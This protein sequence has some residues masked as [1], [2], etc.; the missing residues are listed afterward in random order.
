M[1]TAAAV[2]VRIEQIKLDLIHADP[3]QVRREFHV[4]Q[5]NELA[6]SIKARGLVQPV[7]VV[8]N[9][10]GFQLVAGERRLRAS[11]LAGRADI[12]AVVRTDLKPEDIPVLQ[13]VENLQ[14]EGLSLAEVSGG[15]TALCA[16]RSHD[17][18]AKLLGKSK[19]WV[20]KRVS[21]SA[22]PEPVKKLVDQGAI[23]DPEIALG[24]AEVLAIDAEE[25]KDLLGRIEKPGPFGRPVTREDIR[26]L[27]KDA[28][29]EAQWRQQR[30]A[31]EQRRKAAD[32]KGDKKPSAQEQR[33]VRERE[34][35]E[36]RRKARR[37][38]LR[39]I[40]K[41]C[42]ALVKATQPKLAAVFG[43]KCKTDKDGE[44][45]GYY[46]QEIY[47]RPEL[48]NLEF[49][50]EPIPQHTD[51]VKFNVVLN[52]DGKGLLKLLKQ[53]GIEAKGAPAAPAQE[54]PAAKPK[55]VTGKKK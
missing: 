54:K 36:E 19:S 13:L 43:K 51:Q 44:L 50:R 31:E 14:R 49:G 23:A 4:D 16:S 47:I 22:L 6:D 34:K 42:A 32:A 3:K 17:E 2:P 40:E 55:P 29:Q 7:V 26:D 30:E 25:G 45:L 38:K 15:V 8:P 46:Q 12:P 24:A 21:V 35:E 53:L 37:A 27:V 1:S 28:K 48:A 18:V 33:W 52:L 11:K 39:A 10:A 41:P 20:S 5:L 9:G